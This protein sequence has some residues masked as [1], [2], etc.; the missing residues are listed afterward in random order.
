MALVL[1]P[2]EALR[3]QPRQTAVAAGGDDV[4]GKSLLAGALAALEDAVSG[5]RDQLSDATAR[6]ERA[7]AAI[8]GERQRADALHDRL[9]TTQAELGEQRQAADQARARA[10]EAQNAAE[11][12][13]GKVEAAQIA[14]AAAEANAAELRQAEAER[15][16]DLQAQLDAAMV[17]ARQAGGEVQEALR[18]AEAASADRRS[19]EIARDEERMRADGLKGLLEATQLELAEQRAL[20]DQADDARQ[21]A[22]DAAEALRQADEARKARG[23]LRRA[24]DGWRGR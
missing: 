17:Q 18:T 20:T 15:R 22:H 7:E 23:R 14:Q 21:E 8:A 3:Q 11:M 12:L 24:W 4:P 9:E 2:H 16:A 1:V 10:E 13:R 19:A 5:L 6:A